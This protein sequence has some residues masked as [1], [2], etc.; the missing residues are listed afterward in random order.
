MHESPG[1]RGAMP[2]LIARYAQQKRPWPG[3]CDE[4]ARASG[5][6]WTAHLADGLQA[7][8]LEAAGH[9]LQR[10]A[11]GGH[12]SSRR[13]P[14]L[15]TQKPSPLAPRPPFP[16][17]RIT[18]Q[19][20]ASTPGAGVQPLPSLPLARGAPGRAGRGSG[21]RLPVRR[22]AGR[23]AQ[24][25]GERGG[26]AGRGRRGGGGAAPRLPVS[27]L[28][29][30]ARVAAVVGGARARGAQKSVFLLCTTHVVLASAHPPP[31]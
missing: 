23:S 2:Y 19:P 13:P 12:H 5:T 6:S 1:A 8:L 29:E 22:A 11:V 14:S 10:R 15:A 20:Q 28:R 25:T 16:A 4:L 31:T 27:V 7:V 26:R 17:A 30:S 9:E 24:P 18:P 21:T 3:P